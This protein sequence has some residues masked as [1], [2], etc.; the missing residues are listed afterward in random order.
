MVLGWGLLATVGLA[1]AVGFL[2]TFKILGE[3]PLAVLRQE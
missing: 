3:P 1:V 2:S